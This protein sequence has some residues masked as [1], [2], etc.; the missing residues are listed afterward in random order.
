MCALLMLSITLIA[1]TFVLSKMSD[2]LTCRC[3]ASVAAACALVLYSMAVK[4]W[5]VCVC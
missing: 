2:A 3:A 1:L 5:Q 4:E